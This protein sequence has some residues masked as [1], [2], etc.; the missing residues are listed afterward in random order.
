MK[1]EMPT[2]G[3][4]TARKLDRMAV[5]IF[6]DSSLSPLLCRYQAM[7]CAGTWVTPDS[8]GML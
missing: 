2:V 3:I 8:G 5:W 4:A 1:A 6:M 7:S